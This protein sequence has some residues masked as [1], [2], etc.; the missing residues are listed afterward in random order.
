MQEASVLRE[1]EERKKRVSREVS[2]LRG[3]RDACRQELARLSA[4]FD[5]ST[6]L[7]ETSTARMKA[8]HTRWVVT[9]R[10][11][12]E[13]RNEVSLLQ[14][15]RAQVTQETLAFQR[16]LKEL[17]EEQGRLEEE[18]QQLEQKRRELTRG[19]A[20][21]ETSLAAMH[22]SME[23]LKR[24]KQQSHTAVEN[25]K[26]KRDALAAE[27]SQKLSSSASR[28]DHLDVELNDIT[29]MFMQHMVDRDRMK[30][31]LDESTRLLSALR[32]NV[33]T[34]E[35]RRRSLEEAKTLE[36]A[37][38]S[39]QSA[40]LELEKERESALRKLQEQKKL[41]AAREESLRN[42]IHSSTEKEKSIIIL[43][44][45]VGPYLE[46]NSRIDTAQSR[47]A[48][49]IPSNDRDTREIEELFV[50]NIRLEG[51]C[52]RLKEKLKITLNLLGSRMVKS[53]QDGSTWN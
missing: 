41:K 37:R 42:L 35:E 17:E 2:E 14:R 31:S 20:S 47:L 28:R 5:N 53:T 27:I 25:S 48:E 32:E 34:L 51:E 15:K 18:Q 30:G 36:H 21:M 40:L 24:K 29:L 6:T 26:A 22:D 19:I 44:K 23:A 45:K 50:E 13:T 10:R 49:L 39:L 8:L 43:E 3:K 46:V 38:R 11:L 7:L 9:E 4:E 33:S 12:R 16:E 52:S 1:L